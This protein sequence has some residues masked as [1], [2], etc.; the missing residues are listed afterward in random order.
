[1][2]S[3]NQTTQG[4]TIK[5]HGSFCQHVHQWIT[6]IETLNGANKEN[7]NDVV[8]EEF[9]SLMKKNTLEFIPFP[10]GRKPISTKWGSRIKR[11]VNRINR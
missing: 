3:K 5:I 11:H 1:M 2:Q 10:K 9:Q 8:D 7:W 6:L 4:S